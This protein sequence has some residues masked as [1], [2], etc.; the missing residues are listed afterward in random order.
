VPAHQKLQAL[1]CTFP[2]YVPQS[3]LFPPSYIPIS[4][5]ASV[6][7]SLPAGVVFHYKT[8]G[9]RYALTFADAQLAC[10]EN[11]AHIATPAQLWAAFDDGFTSCAAGW[12][13]DQTVRWVPSP[14]RPTPPPT[15][16]GIV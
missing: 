1:S 3:H 8:L 2:P 5:A 10:Q 12:L 9:A 14:P 13:S 7:S 16:C 4:P 11:S 6:P 15:V